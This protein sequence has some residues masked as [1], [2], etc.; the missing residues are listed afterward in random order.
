MAQER[1]AGAANVAT[2]AT[3]A[4]GT[5][6]HALSVDEVLER[7]GVALD[8]GLAASDVASRRSRFGPNKLAEAAREPR[9]QAFMRQYRDP[10]QIVLLAAGVICLFLPGQF[11]TGVVLIGLTL[12]NA[13][14]GLNQEG[15]AE[16]SIAALQSMMVVKARAL[17]DGEVVQ[18]PMEELVPGDI[19]MI[20]AGDLVPADGRLVRAATLEI[21][22]SALT[23]PSAWAT[24]RP[25]RVSWVS[26]RAHRRSPSCPDRCS[27]TWSSSASCWRPARW[28]SSGGPQ[29]SSARRWPGRWA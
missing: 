29:A 18:I 22:E 26:H 11:W 2:A 12:L 7:Q 8:R 1:T 15:K 3:E 16:S 17:R 25:A 10:M 6:W 13:V 28:G 23:W 21:D 20:E 27:P 19:V 4:T 9:W 14:M 24:P 5:A